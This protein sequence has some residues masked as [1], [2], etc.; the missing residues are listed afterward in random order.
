MM[1]VQALKEKTGRQILLMD[2]AMGTYFNRLHPDAGEAESANLTHPEWIKEIHKK[3]IQ[4]GA[5][6]IRTNTFAVN[7]MLIEKEDMEETLIAAV[8]NAC[9]LYTSDAADEL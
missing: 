4:A 8:R 9:L 1:Q 6:V 7:H 3:Y 5:G 2:G